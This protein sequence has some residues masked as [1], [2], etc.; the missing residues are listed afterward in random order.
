[1]NLSPKTN[2][3][4]SLMTVKNWAKYLIMIIEL[5]EFNKTC[6]AAFMKIEVFKG[7]LRSVSKL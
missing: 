5:I 6:I 4:P 2:K 1:M 7:V 3:I